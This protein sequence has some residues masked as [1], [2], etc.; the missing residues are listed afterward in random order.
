MGFAVL[1][2]DNLRGEVD[3][4]RATAELDAVERAVK[5]AIREIRNIARGVSLPE[6]AARPLCALVQSVAD[7]HAARTGTEVLTNCEA[8]DAID[9]PV[10]VKICVYRFVQEGLNNAWRYAEGKGQEVHLKLANGVL[11]LSVLDSGPG[12]AHQL[13]ASFP[14]A[15]DSDGGM[16]LSGLRDRI[17][18][19]GGVFTLRDRRE[20]IAT[21]LRTTE[22]AGAEL[23]MVLEVGGNNMT[24]IR[25]VVADDHP[26]YREG[27]ARSLA[28][29]PDI[30]VV[31]QAEDAAGAFDLTRDLVPDLV[32]LDISMPSGG[33]VG[34]ISRI[35]ALPTPPRVAMLTASEDDDDVMQAL[36]SG[37]SGYIL[38]AVGSRELLRVVK[39]IAAGQSYVSPALAARI[40]NAMRSRSGARE[41]PLNP[42]DDLSKREED[43]LRLVAEGRSN[44]EVGRALDLQEKT[45]KHYMTS[46]LQKLHV[47]NRVEAAVLARDHLQ[48]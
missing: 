8:S 2:L 10:A 47:R 19:L 7:A 25:I 35:M 40:L 30:E 31:G 12:V 14:D 24:P 29:D 15:D 22:G 27:V 43:I 26:L 11:R 36:K 9:P 16:G 33:G 20:D 3:S 23:S 46:I 48:K 45:V 42:L 41:K 38:K 39:D 18:S 28:D 5:D 21:D 34:A 13:S 44:K 4:P 17:E 37:A 32:L 6:I 1:R